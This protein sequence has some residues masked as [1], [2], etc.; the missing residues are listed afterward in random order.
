MLKRILT[1]AGLLLAAS[2]PAFAHVSPADHG[3]FLAGF[4]H[5]LFGIDH[6]VVMIA[7]GLWAATI[8]GRALWMVPAAFV[9]AMTGGYILSLSGL[10]LPFAEP[11]I[12]ASV[13]ALG[14][15]IAAAVRLPVAAGATL[16]GLFAL[17]H[18][19]AHGS[20]LGVATALPYG[21]GFAFATA[22]LHSAGIGMGLF[23]GSGMGVGEAR[24]RIVAR[25]LG[26]FAA[27]TGLVLAFN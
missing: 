18:G 17:F 21:I 6:I 23:L 24:G 25:L 3:S 27:A 1:A 9:G 15:L 8:G 7:V 13:V 12:L 5:P 20:E 4:S 11:M 10:A 19:Y 22:L 14:L 16:V 2:A 26:G